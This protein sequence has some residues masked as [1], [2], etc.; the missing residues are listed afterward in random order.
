MVGT[1]GTTVAETTVE[2]A[3]Q[4]LT[5]DSQLMMVTCWVLYWV[6]SG[7]ASVVEGTSGA[8]VVSGWKPVAGALFGTWTWPSAI[9]EAP[10]APYP[11]PPIAGTAVTAPAMKAA[12]AIE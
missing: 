5:V 3:G 10:D 8:A 12:A 7:D 1:I 4:F 11:P 6:I 2:L 9:C